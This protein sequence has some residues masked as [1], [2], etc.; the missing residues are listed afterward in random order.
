[1]WKGKCVVKKYIFIESEPVSSSAEKNSLEEAGYPKSDE[2][3]PKVKAD[4]DIEQQKRQPVRNK[5][6]D[7]VA[8]VNKDD[9][10]NNVEEPIDGEP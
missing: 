3:H 2:I 4:D 5:S 7:D 1:M 10:I 8:P 6:Y 9:S